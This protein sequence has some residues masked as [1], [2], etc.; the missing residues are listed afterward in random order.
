MENFLE[1]Q[2]FGELFK[3][4]HVFALGAEEMRD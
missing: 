4:F 2:D 3:I 1:S